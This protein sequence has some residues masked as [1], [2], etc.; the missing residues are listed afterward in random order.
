VRF[1]S[2]GSIQSSNLPT[3]EN[4]TSDQNFDTK[5]YRALVVNVVFADSLSNISKNSKASEIYYDV[6]VLGGQKSGSLLS[7]CKVMNPMGGSF[8]Y[9]HRVLKPSTLELRATRLEDQDGDIVYVSFIQGNSSYPV[10]IGVETLGNELDPESHAPTQEDGYVYKNSYN[11]ATEVVNKFG[12]YFFS[13]KGL[14]N[15]DEA[16]GKLEINTDQNDYYGS[17]NITEAGLFIG[18]KIFAIFT[19]TNSNTYRRVVGINTDGTYRLNETFSVQDE[20]MVREYESGLTITEDGKNDV[21]T[22]ETEGGTVVT[23]NGQSGFINLKVNNTELI[24]NGASGKITL[25]S[26]FVD[27]GDSI[28]DLVVKYTELK[29]Q[30]DSHFHN[31][32]QAISGV[33]PTTPPLVG[34]LPTAGSSKVKVS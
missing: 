20:R 34:L 11:G 17:L 4:N 28:A 14:K 12:D 26:G 18:N 19:D 23:V 21:V 27:L 8:D 1:R 13:V 2:D 10:I 15:F 7:N 25:N 31:A 16:T 32:P 29:T 9:Y 5:I 6:I 30:F 22:I 3:R 24:I 33:I